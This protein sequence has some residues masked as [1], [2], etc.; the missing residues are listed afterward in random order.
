MTVN[1]DFKEIKHKPIVWKI[2]TVDAFFYITNDEIT[3]V[4]FTWEMW[5]IFVS[6]MNEKNM[7]LLGGHFP[8]INLSGVIG[9]SDLW[10]NALEMKAS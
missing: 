9:P 2:F 10:F 4:W 8:L 3:R 1:V 6:N 7:E 5:Q